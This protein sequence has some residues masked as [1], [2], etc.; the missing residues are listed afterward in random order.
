MKDCCDFFYFEN[1][2]SFCEELL[3]NVMENSTCLRE[4]EEFSK[5]SN[6]IV[7]VMGIFE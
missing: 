3:F 4:F 6:L 1:E 5:V 2:T 7:V